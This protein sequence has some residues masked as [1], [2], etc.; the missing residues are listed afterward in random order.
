MQ[1]NRP[2]IKLQKTTFN[3][4][5]E[6]TTLAILVLAWAYVILS[7]SELDSEI[8]VHFNASGE[9]DRY[10]DKQSIFLLPLISTMLFIGLSVLNKYPHIFNYPTEIT[11]ENAERQ[12]NNATNLIRILN[13]IIVLVFAFIIFKTVNARTENS[14]ALGEWFLPTFIIINN[15]PALYFLTKAFKKK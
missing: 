10:G 8:P 11:E 14:E 6:I 5:I 12:Y 13:L 4:L 2:K 1:N 3:Y 7:Y 15:I 9:A